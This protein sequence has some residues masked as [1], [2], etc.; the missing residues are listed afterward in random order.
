MTEFLQQLINGLSLGAMYALIALGYTLVYGVLRFIN[1]AHS[2]VFMV[3]SFAG[4]YLGR[5]LASPTAAGGVAVMLG[6][7]VLCALMGIIIERLAYRP[8]RNRSKLTV[9]ITAIGVSLLLENAGQLIFGVNPR[10]FPETFPSRTFE[11]GGL[12]VSSKDL[13]VLGVTLALL[14]GFEFVVHRTKVGTA[15]RAV[16]FNPQA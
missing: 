11:W 9:L 13:V 8:L 4:L 1:F 6:A 15:M 16:A 3:G 5:S 7:M 12:V 10:A 14:G 2:D